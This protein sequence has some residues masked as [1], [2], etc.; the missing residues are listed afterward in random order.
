MHC[1]YCGKPLGLLRELTDGEFCSGAHRQRYKKLTKQALA[2]LL[3]VQVEDAVAEKPRA[4]LL[5]DRSQSKPAFLGAARKR[6]DLGRL[7][8]PDPRATQMPPRLE[9]PEGTLS[10]IPSPARP[11]FQHSPLKPALGNSA[12]VWSRLEPVSPALP[13]ASF[14]D[15]VQPS[16][17]VRHSPRLAGLSGLLR[18]GGTPFLRQGSLLPPHPVVP[19]FDLVPA[20]A[21]DRSARPVPEIVPALA[22]PVLTGEAGRPSLRL[23]QPTPIFVRAAAPAVQ[24]VSGEVAAVAFQVQTSWREVTSRLLQTIDFPLEAVQETVVHAPAIFGSPAVPVLRAAAALSQPMVEPAWK[25]WSA[26]PSIAPARHAVGYRFVLS[27]AG[28]Q[29]ALPVA[30]SL[31]SSLLPSTAIPFAAAPRLPVLHVSTVL[32]PAMAE[33]L[34]L[35]LQAAERQRL[36]IARALPLAAARVAMPQATAPAASQLAPAALTPIAVRAA[37]VHR[38]TSIAPLVRALQPVVPAILTRDA[39]LLPMASFA[40]PVLEAAPALAASITGPVAMPMVAST[41]TEVKAALHPI[42]ASMSLAPAAFAQAPAALPVVT[43]QMMAEVQALPPAVELPRLPVL[44]AV[45]VRAALRAEGAL[46]DEAAT[47]AAAAVP[48]PEMAAPGPAAPGS[49]LPTL[50][51][52]FRYSRGARALRSGSMVFEGV[53]ARDMAPSRLAFRELPIPIRGPVMPLT[54]PL[55]IVETFHYLRPLVTPGVEPLLALL[56]LWRSV[57]FYLRFATAAACLMLLVWMTA[58]S[59]AVSGLLASRWGA[60]RQGIQSRAAVE[61]SEDFRTGLTDWEGTGDRWDQS[62]S[63]SPAGYIRPGRLA[64]YQPSLQM[65]D[66]RVEFLVQI[67]RKSV[68]WVYRAADHLNYYAAKLTIVK[69]G[70]LPSLSLVRYPVIGG[71]Q[72]DRVEIPIRLFIHNNTPYRVQ[73]SV[74]GNGYTTSIEGQI[75]DFWRDDR[76]QM[77][78]FGFFSETGERARVYWMKLSHQDD[79]IGLVCAYFYENPIYHRR[80]SGE[81]YQ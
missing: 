10:R 77:G 51:T 14:K 49:V 17:V 54:S 38:E 65:R 23:A 59:G 72:G 8:R 58:P 34:T 3:E 79:F 78:G 11:G 9:V 35:Q 50:A 6:A 5:E 47:L 44:R 45:P 48:V 74:Q 63:Y 80:R 66:Y 69:P 33:L 70:P 36:E 1:L 20:Q 67:D 81:V 30:K 46:R 39:T 2:R 55:R 71:T 56:N 25:P 64:L 76:L 19:Q 16:D 60:V 4:S 53:R 37:Q 62:W 40:A 21:D 61:L 24:S 73:L 41:V 29:T 12:P 42:S 22:L 18:Q 27:K 13:A 52:L 43:A 28:F 68:D 31:E 57:P 15:S 7:F 75:V 32:E 26:G